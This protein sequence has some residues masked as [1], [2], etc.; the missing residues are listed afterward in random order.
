MYKNDFYTKEI[1]GDYEIYNVGDFDLEDGGKIPD[2]KLAYKTFGELNEAK[3][4]VIV[5]PTWFSGTSKD[6]EIY[7]GEERALNPTEYFIIIINQ[8]GNGLSSSPHNSPAPISMS[9]FPK[10]RIADD[11]R[12]QHQLIT[13][14]FGIKEV[15]LVVG[16]SMGAQQTYEW[17]VR[18]PDMVKRAAPIAGTA[19]NTIHDFLFTQTLMDAI[20]S[21]PGWNN[22][23][24]NSNTEVADGLKRHADIWSVMGLSTE[25]YQQEK[26][27]L[28]GVESAEEFVTGFLEPFFQGMDPNALLTMAWKWQRGDVSRMTNGNLKEALGRIKAKVFVMPIDEDMFFPPRDCKAEQNMIP[29]S[30]LKVI[31]SIAGHFGLFGGEGSYYHDQIDKHL[32]ELL[33]TPVADGIY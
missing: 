24:Y 31:H 15:A 1:H 16:G 17:A 28:F 32:H 22:G 4:N 6:Y 27:T 26:W 12:A 2:C 9:D 21:D 13:E 10:V 14:K 29:N 11:V 30:E 25:F 8:I 20:T 3:D 5:I 7:I 19:K 18:Y 33:A 23:N